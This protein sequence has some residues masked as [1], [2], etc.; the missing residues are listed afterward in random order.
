MNLN[1]LQACAGGRL[2]TAPEAMAPFLVDWRGRWQGRA[3]AVAQPDTVQAVQATVRWC[4][5]HRVPIVPQGGNTG[6]VG[7]SVPDASGKA[8]LLSLAR[9]NAVRSVDTANG[10]FIAE[11]GCRLADLQGT[12][13]F[14]GRLFPLS[15]S[16]EGTCTLGGNLSSNAGGVQ[17]LRYGNARELCLGLEVVTAE[18]EVWSSLRGLRKDNTGYDLRDLYIGAEGTL[19]VITAATMKLFPQPVAKLTAMAALPGAGQAIGL[20]ELAQRRMDAALTAFELIDDKCIALASRHFPTQCRRPL[21]TACPAWVLLE[22]S[23]SVDA[24]RALQSCEAVL[25]EAMDAGLVLDAVVASSV[26]QSRDLWRLRELAAEAQVKQGPN[27]KHD[28][29]L[30]ISAIPRFIDDMR[31]NLAQAFPASELLVFGHVG[32]GN[33]HFNVAPP[34]GL[35]GEAFEAMEALV[36]RRVY[37]AVDAAGGSIS[38]EHGLGSTKVLLNERYKSKVALALMARIKQALD[39]HGLMNPGRVLHV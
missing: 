21:A 19:G 29:A 32:D 26:A 36:N 30:P 34:P 22:C 20:L 10:T 9:L 24:N 2:L 33:L 18:G 5:A 38:A 23:D 17:V 28:I 15:L 27:F 7:G 14:H 4:A 13:A 25:A 35:S 11:A 8:L 31:A 37:D 16:S 3:L 6:L 39:P 12:A 1:E